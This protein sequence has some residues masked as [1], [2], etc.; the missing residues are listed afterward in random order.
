MSVNFLR[1]SVSQYPP[2][3]A[4]HERCSSTT[5]QSMKAII[6]CLSTVLFRYTGC[7]NEMS[8]KMWE[9]YDQLERRNVSY[10][11][12]TSCRCDRHKLRT[13]ETNVDRKTQLNE[14]WS[15]SYRA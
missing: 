2:S 3:Q 8:V 15:S 7:E 6:W 9:K 10:R 4:S 1:N 14:A 11:R 13:L 12:Q 5:L